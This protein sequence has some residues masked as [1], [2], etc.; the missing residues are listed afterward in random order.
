MFSKNLVTF[1]MEMVNKEDGALNLDW[2]NEVLEGTCVTHQKEI[3]H[4][5]TKEALG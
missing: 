2:E 3:R 4:G 5:P 1:I